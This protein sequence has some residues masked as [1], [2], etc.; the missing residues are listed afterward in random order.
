M[1]ALPQ[2]ELDLLKRGPHAVT[3]GFALELESSAPGLAADEDEPQE[4]E[5]FK[6]AQPTLPTSSHR[7]A[8]ELKQ[9][10]LVRVLGIDPP[11]RNHSGAPPLV[12]AP[13]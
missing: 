7:V 13:A 5:G 1:H 9:A 2:F 6:P 10:G 11:L 8:A 3:P 4:S 12:A